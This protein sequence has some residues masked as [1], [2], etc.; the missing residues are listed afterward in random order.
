MVWGPGGL[1]ER[2][3]V[4]W[5]PGGLTGTPEVVWVWDA[6]SDGNWCPMIPLLL[7]PSPSKPA[8]NW[9]LL[10]GGGGGA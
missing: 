5:S 6:A 10:G 3:E 9:P 1:T 7:P 8:D 4:V 2:P